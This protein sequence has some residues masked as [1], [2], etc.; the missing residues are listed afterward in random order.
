MTSPVSRSISGY[1]PL[2]QQWDLGGEDRVVEGARKNIRRVPMNKWI[3]RGLKFVRACVLACLRACVLACLRACVLACLRACVLLHATP[4]RLFINSYVY[5][6]LGWILLKCIRVGQGEIRIGGV[7]LVQGEGW[8]KG[9]K[10][11]FA[12]MVDAL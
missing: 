2:S 6:L 9:G 7:K 1:S 5:T 10:N 3:K 12:M 4:S 11:K 8:T